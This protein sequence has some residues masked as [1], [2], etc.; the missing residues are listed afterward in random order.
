MKGAKDTGPDHPILHR[1]WKMQPNW[2]RDEWVEEAPRDPA[3]FL[4]WWWSVLGES[5]TACVL[6]ET[7]IKV[8]RPDGDTHAKI[9]IVGEGPGALEDATGVPMVGPLELR[10][11]RC[12]SCMSVQRCWK[13][14]MKDSPQARMG[15]KQLTVCRPQPAKNLVLRKKF[16]LQSAGSV[17]DGILI[18]QWKFS[19]PRHNW[20]ELYNRLHPDNPWTHKSPWFITNTV[21]CRSWDPVK[22]SDV[23]PGV[24]AKNKCRMHLAMQWACVQPQ[25][26]IALGREALECL[27]GSGGQKKAASVRVNEIIETEFGPVIFQQHPAFYLREENQNVKGLQFAKVADTLRRALEYCNFPVEN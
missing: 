14:R 5:C 8:I 3:Q 21:M 25:I 4:E 20:I 18:H 2:V 24:V 16:F 17:L 26:T 13:Y 10:G 15:R 9:M 22:N 12:G 7:R 1:V 11:S 27:I 23:P 6:S 19:Y